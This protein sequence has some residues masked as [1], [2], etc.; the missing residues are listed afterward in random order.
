MGDGSEQVALG[1]EKGWWNDKEICMEEQSTP[2]LS[3]CPHNNIA[4]HCAIYSQ[5]A[6]LKSKIAKTYVFW[7]FQ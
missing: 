5:N 4:H 6:T 1:I 7:N 2:S 3:S